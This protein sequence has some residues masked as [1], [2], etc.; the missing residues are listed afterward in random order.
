MRLSYFLVVALTGLLA[1]ASAVDSEKTFTVSHN[2]VR[3]GAGVNNNEQR[4][5]RA[6][7]ETDDSEVSKTAKDAKTAEEEDDSE[8]SEEE[9]FSLIQ[10]SNR[11]RYYWWFRHQMTP[12]DVRKELGLR[13][14]SIKLVKRS[15]YAGYVKYYDKHCTYYD[16]REK[17]FC[18]AKE[19]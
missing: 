10:I 9:R 5:L 16:N 12:R 3:F 7:P 8:D 1:C 18:K 13:K 2:Q 17:A 15:I 4:F 14:N 11:P 19:Y 6:Y